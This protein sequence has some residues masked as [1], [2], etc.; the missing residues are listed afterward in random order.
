[1]SEEAKTEERAFFRRKV[2][3]AEKERAERW[4][5]AKAAAREKHGDAIEC[6]SSLWG[7]DMFVTV[8]QGGKCIGNYV[9]VEED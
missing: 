7:P 9:F 1:M 8:W 2:S 4:E 3:N 5:R 6:V